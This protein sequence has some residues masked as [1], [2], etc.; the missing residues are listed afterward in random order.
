MYRGGNKR[1][2]VPR[3]LGQP[4]IYAKVTRVVPMPSDS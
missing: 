1:V 2:S 4:T 3:Y